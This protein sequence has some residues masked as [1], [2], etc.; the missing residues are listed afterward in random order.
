MSTS[1]QTAIAVPTR[2]QVDASE[3]PA[4][5]EFGASWCGY[6]AAARTAID[7]VLAEHPDVHYLRI[8]DGRGQPLGRSFHV[9]LWP[10]LVFLRDGI[11]YTRLV[12]PD[13]AAAIRGAIAGIDTA[14]RSTNTPP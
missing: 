9:K 2:A 3:G 13:G 4:V 10:T 1:G 14:P 6:C 8:E 11:E 12:R 5:L 7:T